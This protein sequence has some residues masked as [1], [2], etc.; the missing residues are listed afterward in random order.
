MKKGDLIFVKYTVG[1]L[2][3]CH[4]LCGRIIYI[5]KVMGEERK[6]RLQ[7]EKTFSFSHGFET[8]N[9]KR[10]VSLLIPAIE[11]FTDRQMFID[12]MNNSFVNFHKILSESGSEIYKF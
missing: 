11:I 2:P 9:H 4:A 10:T 12:S 1:T 8:A 6:I 7:V 3:V 5:T